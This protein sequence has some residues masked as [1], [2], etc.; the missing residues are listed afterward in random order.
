[1]G[2]V[3]ERTQLQQLVNQADQERTAAAESAQESYLPKTAP[4]IPGSDECLI[5]YRDDIK[6]FPMPCCAPKQQ[7]E[8]AG[9]QHTSGNANAARSSSSTSGPGAA[10]TRQD[11]DADGSRSEQ[12]TQTNNSGMVYCSKCLYV[13]CA[14]D[15][16]NQL[17][18]CPTCRKRFKLKF[19]VKEAQTGICDVV[20]AKQGMAGRTSAAPTVQE[21]AASTPSSRNTSPNIESCDP[22]LLDVVIEINVKPPKQQCQMCRQMR[23]LYEPPFCEQCHVGRRM[24]FRYECSRCHMIQRIPHPMWKYQDKVEK[25]G[26]TS[27]A[28]HQRCGDYTMWRI[29]PE[30]AVNLPDDECPESIGGGIVSTLRL[31]CSKASLN[32]QLISIP[33]CGYDHRCTITKSSDDYLTHADLCCSFFSFCKRAGGRGCI[34]TQ[35]RHQQELRSVCF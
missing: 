9:N 24:T 33:K 15:T 20:S 28:C 8:Q 34:F 10:A 32:L 6:G 30:D 35:V 5:C 21:E 18:K 22:A 26:N 11:Q 12:V 3:N 1:M 27:W 31:P 19:V 25:F 16:R 17:G 4:L 7:Q 29:V 23:E 13:I 14:T 2:N